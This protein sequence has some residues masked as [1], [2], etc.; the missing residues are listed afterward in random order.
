MRR[1]VK[2]PRA[3]YAMSVNVVFF[4]GSYI[5]LKFLVVIRKVRF[6]LQILV[7]QLV[8]TPKVRP[9]LKRT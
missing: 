9:F 8:P 4:L 2:Q 5:S 7:L 6:K 3:V 1:S